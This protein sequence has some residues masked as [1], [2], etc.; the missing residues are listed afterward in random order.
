MKEHLNKETF[1]E[2]SE[3]L[4]VIYGELDTLIIK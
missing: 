1:L 3:Q 2:L 4:E